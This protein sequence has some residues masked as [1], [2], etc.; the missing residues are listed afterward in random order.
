VIPQ[1][2]N[3]YRNIA[4]LGLLVQL[5]AA[6]FS[7]GCNY[8][9]EHFQVFEF[10]NYKLGL[11]PASQLPWEF[12]AHCRSALQP[13]FAYLF[14]R[15]LQILGLYNPFFVAFLLRLFM[16]IATWL[17]TCR[18]IKLMLP[19]FITQKGKNI[20]VW[21]SFLLWFVPYTGVRFSAENIAGILF[22]TGLTFLPGVLA[23]NATKRNL[24]L[25]IAGLLLGFCFFI[26]LQMAFALLG[27]WAWLIFYSKWSVKTW[28][29]LLFS[30]LTAIGLAVLADYWLY[31]AW[32][33]SPYNY[34][35]ANIIHHMADSFGT[36]PWWYYFR[37][38][39]YS[40]LPPISFILLPLFFIGLWKNIRH[41]FSWICIVFIAGHSLIAHKELRFLFPIIL[42]FIFLTCRGFDVL[43]DRY[44]TNKVLR[45]FLPVLGVVNIFM[46]AL[47][48]FTAAEP[49][50]SYYEAIYNYAQKQPVTLVCNERSPYLLI[51][52]LDVNFYKPRGIN[53]EVIHS[54]NELN[55]IL[56]RNDGRSVIFVDQEPTPP[57]FIANCKKTKLYA[58]YPDW[59]S[60]RPFYD[61]FIGQ[62]DMWAIYKLK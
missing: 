56:A 50:H 53:I 36:F 58:L 44:P 41:P 48:I 17:L 39:L 27:L 43:I 32:V 51:N 62:Q 10:C 13:L 12:G 22:L 26:R 14:C 30:G 61:R 45:W 28:L 5:I 49:N 37:L 4:L 55:A 35:E 3:L 21:C 19:N 59:L 46:L 8:Y 34:F 38:F 57:A 18:V 25:V 16:G 1:Q 24:R 52:N 29:I 6:W 11:S 33:F 42:P 54:G 7:L 40:G 2:N 31:G 9:D 20:Y 15:S 23:A 47:K 60:Y